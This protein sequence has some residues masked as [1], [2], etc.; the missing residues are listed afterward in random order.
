MHAR[1]FRL[2]LWGSVL[3]VA[4]SAASPAAPPPEVPVAQPLA[5][6]VADYEDCTGR[7]EPSASVVLRARVSGYLDK[8][9]FK[10]G[11]AVQKGDVLFVIDPRP[12]QAEMDKAEAQLA[13]AEAHLRRADA[14]FE[15]A[16]GQLA[17]KAVSR[18]DYD[19]IAGERAEAEAGVRLA[20]ASRE[21]ARLNLDFTK[22]LAPITGRIGRP[23]AGP[24][25]P[26]RRQRQGRGRAAAGDAGAGPGRPAG[27]EGGAHGGRLGRGA[28]AGRAASR[29]GDQAEERDAG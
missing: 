15:R 2:W 6:E 8:V 19:K 4:T 21:A 5:R 29:H 10:E 23:R 12:Y 3:A 20:R 13:L 16:K 1:P 28:R 14:D 25:L 26:V 24:A 11:S 7:L 27:G 9:L 22:V 18:E 17:Q